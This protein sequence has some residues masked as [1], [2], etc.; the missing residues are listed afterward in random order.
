MMLEKLQNIL[1]Y[2]TGQKFI[3]DSMTRHLA[4]EEQK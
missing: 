1:H 3:Q 2:N 4:S